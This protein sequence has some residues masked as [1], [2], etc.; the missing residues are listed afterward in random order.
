MSASP[1]KYITISPLGE[2]N[3]VIQ[4]LILSG[5]LDNHFLKW[6]STDLSQKEHSVCLSSILWGPKFTIPSHLEKKLMI[7]DYHLNTDSWKGEVKQRHGELMK[8]GLLLWQLQWHHSHSANFSEGWQD[9][10]DKVH[11]LCH[12]DLVAGLLVACP[13]SSLP[14]RGPA[15][16]CRNDMPWNPSI[17]SPARICEAW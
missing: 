16:P 13:P 8:P 12:Q 3:M 6:E 11:Q 15:W 2:A 17:T 9:G 1:R 4:G 7:H 14:R 10:L 5:R